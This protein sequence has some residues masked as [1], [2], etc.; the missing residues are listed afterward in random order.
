MP[1]RIDYTT[2]KGPRSSR[3]KA[4]AFTPSRSIFWPPATRGKSRNTAQK[5]ATLGV[6]WDVH[7]KA[8]LKVEL[9][10]AHVDRGAWGS[11]TPAS[12][13]IRSLSDRRINVL[14]VSVDL[15]F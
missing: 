4:S 13:D 8:A 10:H 2:G 9:T 14:S 12:D 3:V 6:R 11:F 5:S 7:R 15:S 1:R